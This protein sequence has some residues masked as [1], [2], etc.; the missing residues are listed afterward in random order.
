MW[1]SLRCHSVQALARLWQARERSR[2]QHP[3][4]QRCSWFL[5]SSSS[6]IA[7]LSVVVLRIFIV[8]VLGPR[9][10]SEEAPD[11]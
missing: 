11:V 6:L 4:R 3:V 10:V 2:G 8:F 5:A 9:G 1:A 7:V